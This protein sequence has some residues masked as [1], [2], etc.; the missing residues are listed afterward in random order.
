MAQQTQAQDKIK[1]WWKVG[2]YAIPLRVSEHEFHTT[3]AKMRI[4]WGFHPLRL[5]G[6]A[7]EEQETLGASRVVYSELEQMS[8]RQVRRGEG[9]K[10]PASKAS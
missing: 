8:R 10:R 7:M 2:P 5:V 9:A 6:E 3:R 4:A 1:G